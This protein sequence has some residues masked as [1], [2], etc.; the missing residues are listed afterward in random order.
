MKKSNYIII[1]LSFCLF[2]SCRPDGQEQMVDRSFISITYDSGRELE[3]LPLS[4]LVESLEVV[5]LENGEDALVAPRPVNVTENYI[6]VYPL[7]QE[8]Y[9]LFSKEGKYIGKVGDCGQGPGEYTNVYQGWISEKFGLIYLVPNNAN[10]IMAYD[11]KGNYLEKRSI[12]LP[13]LVPKMNFAIDE[14]K[15]VV[16]V[17]CLSFSDEPRPNFWRQDFQGHVLD[18]IRS[19]RFSVYPD[20]SNEIH[21]SHDEENIYAVHYSQFW[22]QRQDSL[23]YYDKNSNSLIPKFSVYD[24]NLGKE[25]RL[26]VYKDLPRY[27]WIEVDNIDFNNGYN[28]HTDVANMHYILVDK[29][30][31]KEKYCRIVNDYLGELEVN[32]LF[33]FLH[34]S[35]GYLT[36]IYEPGDLLD[37][38]KARKQE[39]D[40]TEEDLKEIDRMIAR[41]SENDN[42][43]VMYGK[44]K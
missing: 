16:M 2:M 43:I 41:L 22:K 9:R 7:S 34:I 5:Q 25:K 32:R 33:A 39:S 42:C 18:S 38:L 13:Y 1:L 11:L 8:A 29:K 19:S 6:G 17:F 10:K 36:M 3:E 37:Q 23:F 31:G 28:V 35:D 30:S 12:P 26:F 20:Y 44:L 27:Y 40:V 24:P 15:K 14:A 4:E 21:L